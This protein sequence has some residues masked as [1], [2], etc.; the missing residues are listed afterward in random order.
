MD[1]NPKHL[2]EIENL[3]ELQFNIT[4]C[5]ILLNVPRLSAKR[6]KQ[7]PELMQAYERGRLKGIAAVRK[8]ILQQAKQGSS[9]A[10]K[11]MLHLITENTR[12]QKYSY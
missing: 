5:C 8:S 12:K 2:E 1:L 9:P 10:Q 4:D 11:E 3:G 6:F 7:E